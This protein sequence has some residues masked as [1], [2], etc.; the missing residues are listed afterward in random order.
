MPSHTLPGTTDE[1]NEKHSLPSGRVLNAEPEDDVGMLKPRSRD[2]VRIDSFVC[3]Y[4]RFNCTG[5]AT[6]SKH[7][8][9]V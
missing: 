7:W 4:S 5:Y 6:V 1:D 3:V 8:R 2:S 9:C